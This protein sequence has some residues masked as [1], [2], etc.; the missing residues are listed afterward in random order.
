MTLALT[1]SRIDL[2]CGLEK[3][4]WDAYYRNSVSDETAERKKTLEERDKARDPDA[5]RTLPLAGYVGKYTH[6][7]YGAATVSEKTGKLSLSS[8]TSRAL[9]TTSIATRFAWARI[10]RGAAIP[11]VVADG[12]W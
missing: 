1:N 6:P 8:A 11:F 3:N 12:E 7:A 4:N 2:Y 5:K 9:S 10:L